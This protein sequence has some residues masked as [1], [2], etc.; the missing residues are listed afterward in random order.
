M[1]CQRFLVDFCA[2]GADRKGLLLHEITALGLE[3]RVLRLQGAQHILV[4]PPTRARPNSRPV[5]LVAHYDR[6]AGTPGANDNSASVL[7]LLL[8]LQRMK[9]L[10]ERAL[11][12]EV[13]VIFTDKGEASDHEDFQVQGAYGL[14]RF[15]KSTRLAGAFFCV[16]HVTGIGDAIVLGKGPIPHLNRAGRD[17]DESARMLFAAQ[18][19]IMKKMLFGQVDFW[20]METPVS[21][22]VGLFLAG[23]VSSQISLLPLNEVTECQHSGWHTIPRTWQTRHSP[24]DTVESLW[25]KSRHV[26]ASVL[27]LLLAYPI[28]HL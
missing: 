27:D 3:G 28:P 5:V 8:L 11:W 15:L 7:D 9:T 24:Q 22:D 19:V 17:A 6:A 20:E 14:G 16:L 4:D 18:R 21:D 25:E 10:G 1:D 12:P 2:A 13:R 26:I 23:I